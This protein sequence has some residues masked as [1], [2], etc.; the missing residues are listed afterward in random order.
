MA[1]PVERGSMTIRNPMNA[2]V[3]T[4]SL[5]AF[6]LKNFDLLIRLSPLLVSIVMRP[7]QKM[8]MNLQTSC[9][10]YMKY[11]ICHSACP[12]QQARVSDC[13]ERRISISLKVA[14]YYEILRRSAPQNDKSKM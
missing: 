5:I 14:L 1:M 9:E 2:S 6:W 3:S 7:F 10:D 8:V 11:F 4:S 12:V 13:K